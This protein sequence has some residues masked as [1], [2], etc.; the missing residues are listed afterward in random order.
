MIFNNKFVLAST[1]KSRYFILKNIGLSF[2]KHSPICDETKLKKELL[3]KKTTPKK[4]SLELAR[5][6]AFSIS[7]KIKDKTIVGSDTV[8]FINKK[9]LNKAKNLKEAKNKIKLIAGKKHTIYSSASVFYNKKEIWYKTQK[10][11]V[12]IRN[13]TDKEINI[14]LSNTGTK[15]LS[16]VGCYQIEA[17]GANIIEYIKGDYFNVMGFPLFPFLNFLK[18]FN[19]EKLK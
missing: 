17:G 4:I 10:T 19:V 15:I 6:K 5:L 9:I 14:Y 1:S 7:K 3:I 2:S 13:L 18:R 11:T 16:S 12:K 8:I